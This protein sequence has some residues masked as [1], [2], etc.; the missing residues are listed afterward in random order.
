MTISNAP[1]IQR[2]SDGDVIISE[3]V[4][5]N[6]AYVVVSGKVRVTKKVNNKTVIVGTLKKGDVF[7]EMGLI[8]TTVRSAS[9]L[10]VGEVTVGFIDRD[11]FDSLLETMP[12]ELKVIIG[13]LVQRLRVTTEM[14]TRIG[15]EL[16]EAREHPQNP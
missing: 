16:A 11:S 14:L 13:A 4:V 1:I 12:E 9:V 5:S 10:A 15:S 7:G 6:S 8:S 2:Y 3:G